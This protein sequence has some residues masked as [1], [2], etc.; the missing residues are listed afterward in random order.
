MPLVRSCEP[1]DL[2]FQSVKTGTAMNDNNILKR[3]IKKAAQKVGVPWVNWL[4]LRRSHATWLDMAGASPKE[5][6]TQMRHSNFETSMNIYVQSVDESQH[7]AIA[8]MAA[9]VAARTV[10]P[11][12]PEPQQLPQTS[13]IGGWTRWSSTT[14]A[15]TVTR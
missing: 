9:M 8:K 3:H 13:R 2:V 7:K 5:I 12:E 15:W 6:Q 11:A 4:C 1:G 14:S 10:K